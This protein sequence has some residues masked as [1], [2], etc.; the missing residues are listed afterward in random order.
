MEITNE[1]TY[2]LAG[3][4]LCGWITADG[5]QLGGA[6]NPHFTPETLKD[7]PKSLKVMSAIFD[8]VEIE[9]YETGYFVAHY[10]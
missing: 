4:T 7:L 10:A 8:F 1:N 6:R 2:C 9:S 3:V 5:Y